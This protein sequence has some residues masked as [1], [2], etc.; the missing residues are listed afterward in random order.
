MSAEPLAIA[1]VI[2]LGSSAIRTMYAEG[3]TAE[4]FVLYAEE[5]EWIE[6]RLSMKKPVNS[7]VFRQR[8]PEF[9]FLA[10]EASPSE[11]ANELR[12][13]RAF[14]RLTSLINTIADDLQKDNALE[15]AEKARAELSNIF[16]TFSTNS[17]VVVED[18]REHIADMKRDIQL[19]KLGKPPGYTTGIDHLDHHWGG[20][21]PGQTVLVLG[22]TGEGKS[23][24]TANMAVSAK[25]QGATIGMF[26]PE[27]STKETRCRIHTLASARKDV[28]KAC[29]LT[30]SFRN[31]A[32]M[33]GHSFNMKSYERFLE[34]FAMDTPGRIHILSGKHRKEK[35]SVSYIED[36]I[37]TLGL[38]YVIIDP[39][40]LLKPVRTY[41]D[42]P[43]AEIG[44]TAE[45][46]EHLSEMY[47]IP[48]VITNQAHRQGGEREDAPHKDKSF[49]SDIPAQLSD[50]VLGVKHLSDENRMICRCTKSRFGQS[51]R[52]ELDFYAN[53]GVVRSTTPITGS[54]YNGHKD[55]DDEDLK[56]IMA[57]VE[58]TDGQ[59]TKTQ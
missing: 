11:L 26:T 27:M 6:K 49:G 43:N 37:V 41:R 15:L 46:I 55:T 32:L 38:D 33:F 23:Y 5:W 7:R 12:E 31:R 39:I 10:P 44:A 17:D 28:Q 22:R 2:E 9:E 36:R 48:I 42:N 13:E 54:Y 16:H 57:T 18:W 1:S 45:A 51:F 35:M 3:V 40:Y 24:M 53:T 30:R 21:L 14:E 56:E 19:T 29:G 58:G 4:D 20:A 25:F 50:Y 52:F 47:N 8:F 34:W 59:E